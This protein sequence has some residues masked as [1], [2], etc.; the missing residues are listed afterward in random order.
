MLQC[1]LEV[2]AYAGSPWTLLVADTCHTNLGK[3]AEAH[4]LFPGVHAT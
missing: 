4:L 2:T 3:L 1:T